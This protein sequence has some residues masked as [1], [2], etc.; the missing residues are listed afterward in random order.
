MKRLEI[1]RGFLVLLITAA[2]VL[3]ADQVSKYLV[4][5]RLQ[6]GQPWDIAPW[7]APVFSITHVTNTGV[8]F[9]LFPGLGEIFIVAG[10][11]AV[12]AI[13]TYSH[14][15]PQGQWL[16]RVALGLALGGAIGNLIDRLRFGGSVVDFI[17]VN[18]W[19]F[20]DFPVFNVA[21]SS[22]VVGVTILIVLLMWEERREQ[23]EQQA[24]EGG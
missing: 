12:I 1:N 9:G 18:F 5:T 6:I 7:L 14:R 2:L 10:V 19:P 24:T 22:I 17:D 16:M 3:L 21:D 4:A 13:V 23:R 8:A 15:L 20:T 11:I